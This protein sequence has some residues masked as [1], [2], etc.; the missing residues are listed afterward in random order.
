MKHFFTVFLLVLS[1]GAG[2]Q[3]AKYNVQKG[4]VAGGYDVVAYFSGKAVKGVA[5]Y[6]TQHN[7]VVYLFSSQK[8]LASFVENPTK[9]EPQYGGW[10][11]YAM[12]TT[13]TKV[14]VNPKTFE[15]RDGKLYLFYNA[16]FNNTLDSWKKENPDELVK[17]ADTTW[18][19]L[20]HGN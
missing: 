14:T 5:K 10:C 16:Y 18:A 13:G 2:A 3:K 11:A 17:R 6:K 8:N 4:A 15:I 7:G 1:L 20:K 9:Y 12:A 19:V